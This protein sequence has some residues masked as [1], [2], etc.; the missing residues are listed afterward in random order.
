LSG[1]IILLIAGGAAAADTTAFLQTML[2][3][4]LVIGTL[5]GAALGLPIE[6]AYLGALLQLL[7]IADLPIGAAVFPDKFQSRSVTVVPVTSIMTAAQV[8]KLSP[9]QYRLLMYTL[10]EAACVTATATTATP[11]TVRLTNRNMQ[12]SPSEVCDPAP[13]LKSRVS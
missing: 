9:P 11:S 6:G 5:L 10:A 13:L 3:Q 2:H 1:W 8:A 4:P 12:L 7:W